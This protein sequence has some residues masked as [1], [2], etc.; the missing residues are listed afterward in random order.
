MTER[1][2]RYKTLTLRNDPQLLYA[3]QM[4]LREQRNFGKA[5]IV[6]DIRTSPARGDNYRKSYTNS[7]SSP[8]SGKKQLTLSEAVSVFVEAS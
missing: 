5:N 3:E 8:A 6:R 4:L 7:D 1:S 2:K